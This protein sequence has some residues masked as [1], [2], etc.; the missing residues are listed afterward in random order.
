MGDAR[1]TTAP[2]RT[3]VSPCQWACVSATGRYGA[4]T[5]GTPAGRSARRVGG[6]PCWIHVARRDRAESVDRDL[7]RE[8]ARVR[9][10]FFAALEAVEPARAVRE[11]LAWD[12]SCLVVEGDGLPALKGVHV[13]AVGKAAVA[14][15]QGALEA[16]NGNIVSGDVITKEG[17]AKAPLP[18]SLRVHEAGHPIPDERGVKATNLAI[19]ALNRLDE[20]VVVLALVS[21]GGSALLGVTSGWSDA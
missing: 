9:E 5:G 1:A 18:P 15:T 2:T 21:G 16:L 10:L 19:S 20:G 6:A 17:H 7:D 3:P 4:A 12:E 13:V 8:R 11:G 14:M